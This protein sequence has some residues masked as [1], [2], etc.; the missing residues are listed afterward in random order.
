MALTVEETAQ[1]IQEHQHSA[2]DVGSTEVQIALLTANILKLSEHFKIHKKDTHSRRGLLK[3]V[4]QR[5]KLLDYLKR[6]NITR[7]QDLIAKLG[8]RR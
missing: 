6:K 1:I 4:N 3:M 7:Y 2:N 8:L 5:R